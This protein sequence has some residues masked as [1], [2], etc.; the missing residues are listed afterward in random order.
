MRASQYNGAPMEFSC[1]KHPDKW[2]VLYGL[3]S[4][5]A[6]CKCGKEMKSKSISMRAIRARG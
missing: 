2:V 5:Q 3:P 6:W 1:S 4:A